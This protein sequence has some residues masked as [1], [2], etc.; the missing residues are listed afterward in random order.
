MLAADC[1]PAKAL[2]G[3]SRLSL[4]PD[5]RT[6][7]A[8]GGSTMAVFAREADGTLR[9]LACAEQYA[10]YR[11]CLEIETG[12]GSPAVSPDG[13]TMYVTSPDGV[14]VF[15]L[16]AAPAG[17]SARV[18]GARVAS[19]R[20]G[21]PATKR[22]AC[23]VRV[24]LGARRAQRAS[25]PIRIARGRYRRISTRIP[26]KARRALAGRGRAS[27]VVRVRDVSTRTRVAVGRVK[28]RTASR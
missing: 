6:L 15:T 22:R 14:R 5:G 16:A 18:A 26:P 20:V 21:C 2:G 23:A 11:S 1:A 13:K 28:L 17:T 10:T 8:S 19:V 4:T 7:V 12:I 24:R 27:A 3:A 9:Q 25:K